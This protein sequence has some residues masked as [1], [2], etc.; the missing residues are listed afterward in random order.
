MAVSKKK[1]NEVYS[2]VHEEILQ[3][4]IKIWKMKDSKTISIAEIDDI[5]SD[6]CASDPQKAIEIFK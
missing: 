5:L 4:R 3:A 6:L 2:V 1:I